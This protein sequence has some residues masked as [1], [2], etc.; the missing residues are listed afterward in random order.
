MRVK[1]TIDDSLHDRHFS[2][3]KIASRQEKVQTIFDIEA[4]LRNRAADKAAGH[5][6]KPMKAP[7]DTFLQY[8][9]Y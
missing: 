6:L 7:L 9:A 2:E 3:L 8:Y 4:Q 5:S 1:S